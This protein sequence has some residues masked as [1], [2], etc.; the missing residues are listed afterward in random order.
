MCGISN[1]GISNLGSSNIEAA[2]VVALALALGAWETSDM[3]I[4]LYSGGI[5]WHLRTAPPGEGPSLVKGPAL[6]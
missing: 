1:E 5:D 3:T 2:G 6:L 4:F